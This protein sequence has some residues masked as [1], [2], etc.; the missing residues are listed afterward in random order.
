MAD[1]SQRRP[2]PG[3]PV[4]ERHQLLH[5]RVLAGEAELRE[6]KL[7]AAVIRQLAKETY[8][9][10]GFIEGYLEAAE[11]SGSLASETRKTQRCPRHTE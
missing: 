11:A 1:K 2:Q 7:R 8:T 6:P 3:A 9:H 10:P 5:E 4:D